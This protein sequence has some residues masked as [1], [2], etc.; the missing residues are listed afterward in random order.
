MK[1]GLVC[2]YDI[3]SPGGVKEHILSLYQEFK[4]RGHSVRVIA[5]RT[6]K[7]AALIL[8]G[9]G[10]MRFQLESFGIVLLEAMAS[11]KP[12]VCFANS[13]YQE[14]LSSYPFKKGLVRVGDTAGMA[15]ALMVLIEDIELRRQLSKWGLREAK[16]YS[17][18]KTGKKVLHYYESKQ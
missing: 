13:G 8:V 1:I 5:P 7:S 2:P 14:V 18:R 16:K 3:F 10:P 12:I 15:K 4:K 11:A 17:W 9:S 6:K